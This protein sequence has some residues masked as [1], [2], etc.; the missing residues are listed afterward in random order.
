M[1]RKR[2]G[3]LSGEIWFE[4]RTDPDGQTSVTLFLI[5]RGS[6]GYLLSFLFQPLLRLWFFVFNG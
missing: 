1:M 2:I 6:P 5:P 3:I 4:R